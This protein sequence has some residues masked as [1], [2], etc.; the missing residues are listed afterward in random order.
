MSDTISKDG[1]EGALK[2]AAAAHHDYESKALGGTPD[3][4]WSG[5]YAAY[6]LGRLGDFMGATDL[7]QSLEAVDT[8]GDWAAAAATAVLAGGR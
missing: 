2:A 1:L 5:F 3:Q 7:A 6:A 8:D 4:Q